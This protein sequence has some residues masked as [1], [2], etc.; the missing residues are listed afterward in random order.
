MKNHNTYAGHHALAVE[1]IY[2]GR[3]S[4]VS[5]C[6]TKTLESLRS[7]AKW[8]RNALLTRNTKIYCDKCKSVQRVS[9]NDDKAALEAFKD[10][11]ER[12]KKD[13]LF[14]GLDELQVRAGPRV[15][16][17]SLQ[18]RAASWDSCTTKADDLSPVTMSNY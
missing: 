12:H 10:A 18:D 1:S 16:E 4:G 11:F 3:G 14:K 15:G 8:N 6:P 2:E 17:S 7:L 5:Q 13:G 9:K